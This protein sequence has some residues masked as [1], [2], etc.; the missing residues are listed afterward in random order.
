MKEE[1]AI[2][3]SGRTAP[4]L[5]GRT[6]I[7]L[8]Y[9]KSG[10][11]AAEMLGKE[12]ALV[13][14]TDASSLEKLGVEAAAIPGGA[15]WIGSEDPSILKG[16]DLVVV[17]P[18]VPPRNP[19]LRAAA[20]R[21]TP[22]MSELEIGWRM[23][24]GPVIAITGTNGKTT[25]TEL[26]GAIARAA[27]WNAIV[28]GNVGTPL[29]AFAGQTADVLVIEVSSFQLAYSES[30]RPEVGVILNLT[31]DHLDWH[32][33]FD[34]YAKAKR[35]M[36]DHQTSEDAACLPAFDVEI[37]R[38]FAPISSRLYHFGDDSFAGSGAFV[39]GS[40][41][42]VRRQGR[43]TNIVRIA[44]WKL[45]GQH[46]RE[47][48][49]AA[50]LSTSLAG[51]PPA[52]AAQAVSE[53][54]SMPHRMEVVAEVNGVQWVNDSKSTNP[55]SLEKALDPNVPT[56]LIAGGVTKGVDFRPLAETI[57]R[58]ARLVLVI[59]EGAIDME[60]AWGR[61][62]PVVRAGTLENAVEI[63]RREALA[64]ERVLLSPACASFDQFRNYA[65]R[66]DRFREL[67]LQTSA[68]RGGDGS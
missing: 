15:Q 57:A 14:V 1:V 8:G 3:G 5:R 32:P 56:I 68:N 27:G 51:I 55:G 21:G 11:A 23:T 6:A 52:A 67:V 17:S 12:G 4:E 38:R 22:V 35:R 29:T 9:G 28:A 10:R 43:E 34:D 47:N 48:L 33:D 53:F 44:E 65:H 2:T 40:W 20:A 18:G 39:R 37:A 30:F 63:A 16:A 25:T 66:G 62:T 42:V 36:F 54:R 59:G 7:V 31:E 46:N 13:R 64:G 60:R 49:L 58:G 50:V 61:A 41:V 19:I 45:A 24:K 26:A